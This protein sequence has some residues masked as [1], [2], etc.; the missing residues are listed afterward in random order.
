MKTLQKNLILTTFGLCLSISYLFAQNLPSLLTNADNG[1]YQESLTEAERKLRKAFRETDFKKLKD[2]RFTK[3]QEVETAFTLRFDRNRR[4]QT[5][6]LYYFIPRQHL[7]LK[8]DVQILNCQGAATRLKKEIFT[9]DGMIV[10]E[11]FPLETP[12]E[13]S[14]DNVRFKASVPGKLVA[15]L[16]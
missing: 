6:N 16:N 8:P 12:A 2:E 1:D 11:V 13:F 15:F 4:E 7:K 3:P 10:Y 14:Q 9:R 5:L